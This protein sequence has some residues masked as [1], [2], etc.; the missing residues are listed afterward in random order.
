MGAPSPSWATPSWVNYKPP[1]PPLVQG[2][3]A[4]WVLVFNAGQHDEGVYTHTQEDQ[5]VSSVVAFD[6]TEDAL[7]FN[8]VLLTKGFD[9]AKP[10]LWGADRL[11]RFCRS[12]GLEVTVV[13]R[14]NL[15]ATPHE[16]QDQPHFGGDPERMYPGDGTGRRDQYFEYRNW[17]EALFPLRPE[18]C[19]DDDCI[20]R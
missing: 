20:I 16:R 12:A 6:C 19:S 8:E 2:R 10:L 1:P 3:K 17:L 9:A 5:G 7:A 11:M 15:P 18:N 4:V 13:P 14:G